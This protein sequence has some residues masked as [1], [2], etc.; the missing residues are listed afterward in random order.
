MSP[1]MF[2]NYQYMTSVGNKHIVQPLIDKYG[3]R[4]VIWPIVIIKD[5]AVELYIYE[6]NL[7]F[8][9]NNENDNRPVS[10]TNLGSYFID[11]T[12][13]PRIILPPFTE[14]DPFVSNTFKCSYDFILTR[15]DYASVDIDYAWLTPNGWKAI[16]ATTV[17]MPLSNK[18]EAE[19]LVR[20]F[21]KRPSW[22]GSNGPHGIRKLISAVNDLSLNYYMV[23][24]N[25]VN[26]VSNDIKTNGNAFWFRLTDLNIDRILSGYAPENS[27]FGTYNDFLEW[28]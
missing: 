5:N 11:Y 3:F 4:N 28:L 18:Q 19:R 20:M 14:L 12:T 10:S 6:K 23:V 8:D 2:P 24:V 22:Q 15:S 7:A 13:D 25:S 9:L 16:E 26:K 1:Q 27:L 17:W 21:T